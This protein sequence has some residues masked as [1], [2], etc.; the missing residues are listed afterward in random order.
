MP[1]VMKEGLHLQRGTWWGMR[2]SVSLSVAPRMVASHGR[3]VMEFLGTLIV[4]GV[5]LGGL[6]L[7]LAFLR[8]IFAIV[9]S[10]ASPSRSSDMSAEE[11]GNVHSGPYGYS[12]A[13][14]YPETQYG[15]GFDPDAD[16]A[17]ENYQ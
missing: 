10:P 2:Y 14:A 13:T 8:L 15:S 7:V 12:G 16:W 3:G 1:T 5:V 17:E 4:L 11:E 6:W 9:G